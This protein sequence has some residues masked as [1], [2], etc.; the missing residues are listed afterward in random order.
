MGEEAGRL[1]GGG[2]GTGR[3][4]SGCGAARVRRPREAWGVRGTGGRPG[5]GGARTLAQSGA[6]PW[7]LRA[8]RLP[9]AQ[10]VRWS[11]IPGLWP[12]TSSAVPFPEL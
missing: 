9:G 11:G 2:R 5:L 1:G 7:A 10:P 12:C 3:H 4:P 8:W 6:A